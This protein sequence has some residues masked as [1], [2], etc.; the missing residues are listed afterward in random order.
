MISRVKKGGMKYYFIPPFANIHFK[1]LN[2][3]YSVLRYNPKYNLV[4]LIYGK[5]SGAGAKLPP[6]KPENIYHFSSYLANNHHNR[7]NIQEK[8]KVCFLIPY[9][10]IHSNLYE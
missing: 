7:C 1:S 9:I 2:P 8:D 4:L 10:C 5:V 3:N 6:P